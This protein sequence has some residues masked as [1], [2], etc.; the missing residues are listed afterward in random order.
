M[1]EDFEDDN[2]YTGGS[3]RETSKPVGD[4]LDSHYCPAKSCYKN[5]PISSQDG[6]AI[7]IEPRDHRMTASYGS[8]PDAKLYRERQQDLVDQG[9]VREAVQMDIDDIRSKFGNKYDSAIEEMELYLDTLNPE[10]FINR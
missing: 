5:A 4:G 8:S 3:H 7:K 1:S 6:P 2:P 10:D 9:N